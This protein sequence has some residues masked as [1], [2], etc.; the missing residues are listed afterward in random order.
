MSPLRWIVVIWTG[1]DSVLWVWVAS[2]V[3]GLEKETSGFDS[4]ET[5]DM[6]TGYEKKYAKRKK[7]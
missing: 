6:A 1:W 5:S 3:V 7:S 2:L 4:E